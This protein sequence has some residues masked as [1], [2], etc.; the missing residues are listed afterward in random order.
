MFALFEST[1]F[2]HWG[3]LI[4]TVVMPQLAKSDVKGPHVSHYLYR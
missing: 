3:V 4:K 1:W 2:S